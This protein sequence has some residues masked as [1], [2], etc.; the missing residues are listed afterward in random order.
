MNPTP[1]SLSA[2][3]DGIRSFFGRMFVA[4]LALMIVAFSWSDIVGGNALFLKGWRE[5]LLFAGIWT[6][7][8]FLYLWSGAGT[9]IFVGICAIVLVIGFAY[10]YSQGA[11]SPLP[12]YL[13]VLFAE[14]YCSPLGMDETR[15]C[16]QA[17]GTFMI[18]SLVYWWPAISGIRRR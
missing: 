7:F 12:F 2:F 16:V 1:N 10:F 15:T 5:L 8:G 13:L 4:V 14:I 6:P 3:V 9:M 17:L 11:G 18:F